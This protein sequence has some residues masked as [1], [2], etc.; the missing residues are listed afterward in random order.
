MTVEGPARVAR[1]A[2]AHDLAALDEKH[3]RT[4]TAGCAEADY[5]GEAAIVITPARWIARSDWD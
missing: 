4:D 3:S 5:A 2:M 1:P